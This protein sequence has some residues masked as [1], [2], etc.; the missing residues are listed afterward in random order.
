MRSD[1]QKVESFGLIAGP[2]SRVLVLG[3]VPSPK[4]RELQLNYGNPR[5][6]F[7]PVLGELF[8]EP[9][10]PTPAQKLQ[11]ALDHGLALWDVLA[12]C[13]IQG[14]SDASIT[15]AVPNN[16]AWALTQAP[17]HSIF[18]TGR[19]AAELYTRLIEPELGIPC[20]SLPST[21]PANARMRLADLVV[22]YQPL[23][24]A[25]KSEKTPLVQQITTRADAAEKNHVL[26]GNNGEKCLRGGRA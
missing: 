4:S 2:I 10:P 22:A 16:I 9:V 20:S 3:T 1:V 15:Q 19:K 24:D 26:L 8:D 13:Q 18:C 6:R 17:I 23:A 25:L 11:F 7:W 12:S 14:A 5:N 21:S